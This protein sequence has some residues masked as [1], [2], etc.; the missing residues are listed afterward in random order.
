MEVANNT[1]QPVVTP[2]SPHPPLPP[3]LPTPSSGP[4]LTLSFSCFP[5]RP[6]PAQLV[7][8]HPTPS[9][10]SAAQHDLPA[11]RVVEA[12]DEG[13]DGALAASRSPDERC[14][15]PGGDG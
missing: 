6:L 9:F 10:A 1:F 7:P 2:P 12:L 4:L 14:C 11:V 5:P 15:L 13:D 3:P 8:P